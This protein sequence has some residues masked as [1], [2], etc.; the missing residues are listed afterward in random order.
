MS[1]VLLVHGTTQAPSGFEGLAR[2]LRSRGHR[3]V[4]GD[5][6]TAES[7]W[8]AGQFAELLAQ[9]H[10][11]ELQAPVVVAHSASGL[12]LPSI[13]TALGA[14]QHVWL[15]AAVPDFAGQRSL[16][17]ELRT[18]PTVMFNPEWL[19]IDPTADPVL[20]TYFLFHDCNLATLR[21]ALETVR[22]CD[23]R[24]A[25][26]EVPPVDPSTVPSTY[27]LPTADRALRLEWMRHMARDRLGIEP[28]ELPGGHNLYTANPDA[29]AATIVR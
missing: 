3:V 10:A 29:V 20:A 15:A 21:A 22:G 2:A 23:L 6:P 4:L 27:L 19:G 14:S 16:L 18:D 9:R 28:I 5:L 17:D 7:T 26:G 13:S 11:R 24:G 8:T 12:L 1:D 25:Y